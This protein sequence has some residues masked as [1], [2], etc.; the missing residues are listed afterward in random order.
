LTQ[1]QEF[2]NATEEE[3]LINKTITSSILRIGSHGDCDVNW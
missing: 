2:I 1:D 3:K